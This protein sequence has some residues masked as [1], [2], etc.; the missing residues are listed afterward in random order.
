MTA[1]QRGLQ[2]SYTPTRKRIESEGD[3]NHRPSFTTTEVRIVVAALQVYRRD[4]V[5]GAQGPA[6]ITQAI[7]QSDTVGILRDRLKGLLLP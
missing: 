2:A 1:K 4:L 3:T 5:A 7:E 6:A